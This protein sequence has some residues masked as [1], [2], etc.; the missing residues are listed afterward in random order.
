M[1]QAWADDI[2]N[3]NKK[4]QNVNIIEFHYYIWNHHGKCIQISTKMLGFGLVICEI[5]FTFKIFWQ[6]KKVLCMVYQWPHL[7]V[8]AHVIH[9]QTE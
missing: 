5:G 7:S 4:C 2:Q 9:S 3:V 6:S 1:R 8:N